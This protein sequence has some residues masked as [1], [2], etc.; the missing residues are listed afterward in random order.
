VGERR[1]ISAVKTI[2]N[3]QTSFPHTQLSKQKMT[4]FAAQDMSSLTLDDIAQDEDLFFVSHEAGCPMW[5]SKFPL[6]LC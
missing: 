3:K 1:I 2:D 6:G 5:T 4:S